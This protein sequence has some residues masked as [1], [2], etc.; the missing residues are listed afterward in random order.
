MERIVV[1]ASE[2]AHTEPA[3]GDSARD[4]GRLPAAIPVWAKLC[5]A[6]LVLALPLLGVGSVVLRVAVRHL[7]P[8]QR[9]AWASYLSTLLAISGV[10]TTVGFL[11]VLYSGAT[12]PMTSQ[13][14]SELDTR[15][16]YPQLPAL[17]PLSSVQ[18]AD[19]LKPLV[20]VI[21]P[22]AK[23]LLGRN[24]SPSNMLGAGVIL[25][26]SPEGY[27]IATARHVVDGG[28]ARTGS[29]RVLVASASG[30]W[31]GADVV[32]RHQTLDLALVWLKR[33]E[34]VAHFVLPVVSPAALQVGEEISA[35]G[36]PQGLRFSLS[37]GIVSRK[38]QATIQITAPVS[39][40]N[41]GGPVFDRRGELAGI[42]IAM[43]DR[44][45]SP[46]A[47]NLNFAVDANALLRGA[48]W[49]YTGQGK[50]MLEAFEQAQQT[51][52]RPAEEAHGQHERNGIRLD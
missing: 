2:I 17:Q 19:E 7:A 29:G 22:A 6:P 24:E 45:Q 23:N 8:R 41:S 26:A 48:E 33:S 38:D 44:G 36:H 20:M 34:G 37:T 12:P 21:T 46:N 27:L 52:P 32:A 18:T 31:T 42:V 9:F 16:E 15:V 10:L 3:S 13:G 14:L 1:T 11:V 47:E 25:S 49:N 30:T 35:I 43:V 40:G 4:G 28:E 50:R 51:L 39:P 5:V